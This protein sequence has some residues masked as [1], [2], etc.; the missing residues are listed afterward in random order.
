MV[1]SINRQINREMYSGC[2][3]MAMAAYAENTGFKGV[4]NW[5]IVQMKE[6]FAHAQ[7]FYEYVNEQGGKVVLE[8]IEAPPLDMPY[9]RRGQGKVREDGERL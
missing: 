9:M 3:Y 4:A 8:E 2:F 5:S 6:E 7:K 1:K